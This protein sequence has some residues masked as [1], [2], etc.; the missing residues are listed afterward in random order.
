MFYK[1]VRA[2]NINRLVQIITDLLQQSWT[3]VGGIAF[4]SQ[5]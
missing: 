1:V 3:P 2:D 5:Q 4:D